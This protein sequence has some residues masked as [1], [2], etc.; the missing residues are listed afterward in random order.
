MPDKGRKRIKEIQTDFNACV[1]SLPSIWDRSN[2]TLCPNQKGI[3]SRI[4]PVTFS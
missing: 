2:G 1:G 4:T 3:A